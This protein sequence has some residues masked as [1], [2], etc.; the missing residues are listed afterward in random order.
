VSVPIALGDRRALYFA[1][2]L[3]AIGAAMLGALARAFTHR[4]RRWFRLPVWNRPGRFAHTTERSRRVRPEAG[5]KPARPRHCI[6][7]DASSDAPLMPI[8]V[9]KASDAARSQ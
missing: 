7:H 8:G 1:I 5:A 3:T 4:S 2:V 9:G 6:G